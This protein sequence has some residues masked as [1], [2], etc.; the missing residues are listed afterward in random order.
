[1]HV[2]VFKFLRI[3]F[4]QRHCWYLSCTYVFILFTLPGDRSTECDV[5]ILYTSQTILTFSSFYLFG[6]STLL[7][8]SYTSFIISFCFFFLFSRDLYNWQRSRKPCFYLPVVIS[9]CVFFWKRNNL[10]FQVISVHSIF[11]FFFRKKNY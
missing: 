1:M 11:F 2:H 7:R 8:L 4:W 5:H 10:L 9:I 6:S 3:Y